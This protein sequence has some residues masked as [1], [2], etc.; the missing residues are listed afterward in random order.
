MNRDLA[1]ISK[2]LSYVLRHAPEAEGLSM[3]GGGWVIVQDLLRTRH[4]RTQGLTRSVLEHVVAEI[5][6]QRFEF[7][8]DG[9][10]L[11]GGSGKALGTGTGGAVREGPRP[12]G[13]GTAD[14]PRS[15]WRVKVVQG[16]GGE[17]QGPFS[18]DKS[19]ASSINQA[20]RY[21]RGG[22]PQPNGSATDRTAFAV[23]ASAGGV[24][25]H[26]GLV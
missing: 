1:K 14:R 23:P 10:R 26:F 9:T 12:R 2:Y 22:E 5:D 4:A 15:A 24:E 17:A 11:R 20:G 7:S 21:S 18:R 16:A 25:G 19:A 3:D 13:P 8:G 6:K